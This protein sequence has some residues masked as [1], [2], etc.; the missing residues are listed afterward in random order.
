MVD[1]VKTKFIPISN[2]S[3]L[4]WDIKVNENTGEER[5]T[6][7][8]KCKGL[9]FINKDGKIY[10]EG[11]FQTFFNDGQNLLN[12]NDFTYTDF[13]ITIKQFEK[14]FAIDP[15]K[16]LLS[17]VEFGVNIILP[18]PTEK[19]LRS[20]VM[21]IDKPF[22][23]F[24]YSI[25][26]GKGSGY[27][28]VH[29]YYIIK[30]YDKGARCDQSK[31]ILRIEIKAIKMAF[32]Q[33]YNIPI[34]TLKDLLNINSLKALGEILVNIV[35]ECVVVDTDLLLQE[36]IN[37]KDKLILS[38]GSNAKYWDN[39]KPK[40]KDYQNTNKNP[41]YKR[42]RKKYYKEFERFENVLSKYQQSNI[43]EQVIKLTRN[44]LTEL[45]TISG[46]KLTEQKEHSETTKQGDKLT[47]TKQVK[48]TN[49]SLTYSINLSPTQNK[50]CLT[51]KKDISE[52]RKVAKFC[53]KKC[54][55][56]FTDALLNPTNNL[57]SRIK[58]IEKIPVLFKTTDLL[59]QQHKKLL[60]KKNSIYSKEYY[61][62]NK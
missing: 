2:H 35:N 18:F 62:L 11:S 30:F 24:P 61:G 48:R 12:Y 41:E 25:T 10:L 50:I 27:E 13:V 58:R 46:D 54:K 23:K 1:G 33:Y 42:K 14:L 9:K 57:K 31:Y 3:L 45:L 7:T 34:Q 38:N 17:N 49:S 47:D 59:S 36:N 29:D 19:F 51:C 6:K 44:K 39:L 8:F 26:K 43:K 22:D 15:A 32:F 40:S 37:D 28:A 52:K 60:A 55:N 16:V 56:D 5:P 53:S 20:L 21:H 4:D